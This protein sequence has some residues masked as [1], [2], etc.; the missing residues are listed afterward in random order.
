MRKPVPENKII[1]LRFHKELCEMID[2]YAKRK[3]KRKATVVSEIFEEYISSPFPLSPISSM[4][5][6]KRGRGNEKITGKGMNITI[7]KVVD[8]EIKI[9][10]EKKE[11][12]ENDFRTSIIFS[13]LEKEEGRL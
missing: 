10:A 13:F 1:F 11:M 3:E 2:E 4:Y 6:V 8:N 5:F 7:K 12:K 9:Q